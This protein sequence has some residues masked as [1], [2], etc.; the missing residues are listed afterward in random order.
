MQLMPDRKV[1]DAV[2]QKRVLRHVSRMLIKGLDLPLPA[3][4]KEGETYA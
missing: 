1:Y 3:I 4:L 2:F